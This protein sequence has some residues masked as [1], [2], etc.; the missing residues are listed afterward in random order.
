MESQ[1][2]LE[3]YKKIALNK[4]NEQKRG[5]LQNAARKMLIS[6]ATG[7]VTGGTLASLARMHASLT[8]EDIKEE[9]KSAGLAAGAGALVGGTIGLISALADW[10]WPTDPKWAKE[11]FT[12]DENTIDTNQ[13]ITNNGAEYILAKNFANV[14]D[15]GFSIK[16]DAQNKISTI[17]EIKGHGGYEFHIMVDPKYAIPLFHHLS[18]DIPLSSIL[19][20]AFP[21]SNPIAVIALRPSPYIHTNI[22]GLGYTVARIIIC[23]HKDIQTPSNANTIANSIYLSIGGF[24]SIKGLKKNILNPKKYWPE[25][26]QNLTP[27]SNILFARYNSIAHAKT[28]KDF[29]KTWWGHDG[30]TYP[31]IK[32]LN[33]KLDIIV[34][35]QAQP[36][37]SSWLQSLYWLWSKK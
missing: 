14:T 35:E 21:N 26:T 33:L 11:L 10:Y 7:G 32:Q 27:A 36:Q 13:I 6:G 31:K 3:K 5:L 20:W 29:T 19:T 30:L 37:K 9:M 15:A 4:E 2:G 22:L 25:Y 18:E 23:A 28:S 12:L 17:D 34:S 16:K 24:L 8:P 1:M